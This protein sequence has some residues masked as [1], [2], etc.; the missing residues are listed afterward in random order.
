MQVIRSATAD[1]VVAIDGRTLRR[2]HEKG[3]G[4]TVIR[5][6]IVSFAAPTDWGRC[7]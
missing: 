6:V 3:K 1:E 4:Q 7:G 5:L 2:S